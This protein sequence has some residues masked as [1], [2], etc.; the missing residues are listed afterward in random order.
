MVRPDLLSWSAFKSSLSRRWRKS[1][2]RPSQLCRSSGDS[3][4][5][6]ENQTWTLAGRR[7]GGSHRGHVLCPW[8]NEMI[9][10]PQILD[11]I[12][13]LLGP[14]ILCWNARFFIKEPHDPGFVSWHQDA[15]YWGLDS[16]DVA[17]AWLA[18][19][20]ANK[21]SGCMQFIPGTHKQQVQHEDT[22]DENNLLTRGQEIAVTD[23]E[24]KAVYVE[25]KPVQ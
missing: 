14:D 24:S 9:R 11:A 18:M 1:R 4:D 16:S 15:T 3:G 23:D 21:V 7:T 6:C 2:G 22:F 12:E 8:I 10:H 13:D 17:T 25:L 5:A 19:S 20:P